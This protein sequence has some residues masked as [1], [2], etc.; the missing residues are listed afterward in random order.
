MCAISGSISFNGLN[1]SEYLVSS[2]MEMMNHRGPDSSGIWHDERV[3]LGH[4]RL[5]IIDVSPKANQPMIDSK[6]NYIISFNG[7][8]F[9]YKEI[10][11]KLTEY[12]FKSESDTE[13]LLASFITWG[14]DCLDYIKGQFAFAI[15][16]RAENSLFLARDHMGEKPL[17]YVLDHQGF[18]FSSELRPLVKVLKLS[19]F[20]NRVYLKEFLAFQSVKAPNTLI[21]EIKQLQ[22]GHYAYIKDNKIFIR[23]Y[24]SL[25]RTYKYQ[26]TS[27]EEIET[28]INRHL[29][30]AVSNQLISDVPLGAFLS[31]GLDSSLIVALASRLSEKK[32]R[33]FTIGF[34]ES[35]FDERSYAKVISDRYQTEH[36][37]IIVRPDDLVSKIPFILQKIDVPSGDGINSFLVSELVKNEGITVALS[38]LGGDELFAGYPGFRQY[39]Y[40]EKYSKIF[41]STSFTRK[42]IG[43]VLK[44]KEKELLNFEKFNIGKFNELSRS[45]FLQEEIKCLLGD[46]ETLVPDEYECNN[47]PLLS[48]YSIYDMSNYTQPVLLKDVDQM[49]MAVSLEVRIPFFDKDLIQYVLGIPDIYK[50]GSHPKELLFDSF[51]HLIPDNIYRRKKMG[52]TLPWNEWLSN[53]LYDFSNSMIDDLETRGVFKS[54]SVKE[55][56][57]KYLTDK[58]GWN[59]IVL[60]FTLEIW[61]KQ[62]DEF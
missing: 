4:N 18:H 15:W 17:Y 61:F 55:I 7:E 27:K 59:K 36:T 35:K 44:G 12:N 19:K 26:Y 38:G 28:T 6:G 33:T 14:K 9:N 60:L 5:A 53:E 46:E 58:K 21:S 49:G 1:R 47:F 10:K 56:W 23:P 52:F 29:E 30:S 8:I 24:W 62:L 16:N 54:G 31:G 41:D 2:M 37:E 51:K 43:K 32:I 50:I 57:S 42:L 34:D 3:C 48:R 39:Y 25:T 45:I 20:P 22:P 13:V 40:L 11:E